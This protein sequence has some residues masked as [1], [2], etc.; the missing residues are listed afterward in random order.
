[1]N[2]YDN[3]TDVRHIRMND[4]SFRLQMKVS[5]LVKHVDYCGKID[6]SRK[7]EWRFVETHNENDKKETTENWKD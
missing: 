5:I 3:I 1:M 6:Y 2:D 7:H 4:G